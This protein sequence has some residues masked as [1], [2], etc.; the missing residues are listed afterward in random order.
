MPKK[1]IIV[2]GT[3]AGGIEACRTI[4]GNLPSDFAASVFIV[5]HTGADSPGVLDLIL[6]RASNLPTVTPHDGEQIRPGHIYVA[7]PDYHMLIE[8]SRICL[9]RGP[10]ENRFR[11]A[12]D[13]L[14]RSAAQVYGPRVV[15]VVLTGGLDDGSAG[16][17]AIKQL[18]GTAVVQNPDDALDRSMPASALRYVDVDYIQP[19]SKIGPLLVQLAATEAE[20]KGVVEVPEHLDVEVKIA[21]QDPALG[22]D[23]RDLWEK[24][25]YTCPECHGVLLQIKEGGHDRYRCHTGHAFSSG[26]LLADLTESVEDSLWDSIRI[27]EESV[28]LLRHMAE[29]VGNH[30]LALAAQFRGK[31]E[32]AENRSRTVRKALAQH[33]ELMFRR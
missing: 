33:E 20:D 15:G 4:L 27:I 23:V 19:L 2:I 29:H 21:K 12:V 13:P 30:D 6:R 24:S 7:R 11:P 25:S 31:A 9:S 8:P 22:Q 28:L 16:L 18:S 1:D 14:F 26:S 32:E 10:K 17:W 5:Q 3:S